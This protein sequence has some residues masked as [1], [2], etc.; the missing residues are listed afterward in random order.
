MSHSNADGHLW[1][2]HLL[3]PQAETFLPIVAAIIIIMIVIFTLNRK[4]TCLPV[5][6]NLKC[7][8]KGS[9]LNSIT[10]DNTSGW[11]SLEQGSVTGI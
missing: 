9:L 6:F 1:G 4:S 7:W 11:Y 2:R 3:S 8:D 10:K 5:S